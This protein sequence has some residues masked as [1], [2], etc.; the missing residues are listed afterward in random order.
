MQGLT[1]RIEEHGSRLV[2]EEWRRH[3]SITSDS[4][5]PQQYFRSHI[6]VISFTAHSIHPSLAVLSICPLYQVRQAACV[7]LA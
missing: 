6:I 3:L 7:S 4:L 5:E 2:L 1:L